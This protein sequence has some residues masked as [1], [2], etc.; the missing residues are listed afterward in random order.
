MEEALGYYR[1]PTITDDLIAF[2]CEDCVWTVPATGG[3]ARRLTGSSGEASFPRL[4]PDG[5]HIAFVG[6]DEGNPE[7]YVIPSGGGEAVRLTFAGSDQCMISGWTPDGSEVLF[8]S[9]H[10]SPFVKELLPYAVRFAG[11]ESR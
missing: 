2:V 5:K 4:S 1:Y 3:D 9:D 10:R 7:V 6:R 11:G 8:T